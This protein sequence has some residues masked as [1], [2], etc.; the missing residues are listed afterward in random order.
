M[1]I[2]PAPSL[3]LL[4]ILY[5]LPVSIH[6]LPEL[7]ALRA[8]CLPLGA[9][10]RLL[11]DHPDQIHAITSTGGPQAWSIMIKIDLG[12]HRA[13]LEPDSLA[14]RRLLETIRNASSTCPLELYGFYAHAGHSYSSRS[15]EE[16]DSFLTAE[17]LAVN[18]AAKVAKEILS[19]PLYEQGQQSWVLSVG[20]TPTAHA[21]HRAPT[22]NELK[23]T[24]Q[25]LMGQL[26]LHAGNYPLLDLQQLATRAREGLLDQQPTAATMDNVAISVL[27]SVVS[28]YPGRNKSSKSSIP[29][30]AADEVLIDGASLAFSKDTGPW[31]GHGHVVYPTSL[32]GWELARPS[33]EHGVMAVRKGSP[34]DWERQWIIADDGSMDWPRRPVV[35]E[36]LRI[37]PQHACL[38]AACHPWFFIIDSD[39]PPDAA[40]HPNEASKDSVKLAGRIDPL[41]HIVVDVW[42][43]AKGW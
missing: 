26:E 21:A 12:T 42:V 29:S 40:S 17:V 6:K 32:Q 33:Q 34:R 28:V 9:K 27:C 13:G 4:Q 8:R 16:A 43:P 10:V 3:A 22:D 5:G 30:I 23:T 39:Q 14:L 25:G 7:L 1:L 41:E 2:D 15:P 35:G 38:T 31:G 37:V 20:S 18:R 36:K 11:V 19:D 24:R